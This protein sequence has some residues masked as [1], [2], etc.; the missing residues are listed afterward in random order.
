MIVTMAIPV[1][2]SKSPCGSHPV[3]R[4]EEPTTALVRMC[5]IRRRLSV[6]CRT[7]AVVGPDSTVASAVPE[8]NSL[9]HPGTDR[10]T[11]ASR[12]PLGLLAAASAPWSRIRYLRPLFTS[13]DYRILGNWCYGRH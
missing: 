1:A 2:T 13:P 7:G 10:N 8:W 5:G 3:I 4:T 6:G 9:R 11:M 12:Q